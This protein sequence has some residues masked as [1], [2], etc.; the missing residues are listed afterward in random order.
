[1]G[2]RVRGANA[3][4][5]APNEHSLLPP[6]NYEYR[7]IGEAK[8][9]RTPL[10]ILSCLE[11]AQRPAFTLGR[12]CD[13]SH[14]PSPESNTSN[15]STMVKTTDGRCA[16]SGETSRLQSCHLVPE[17]EAKWWLDRGMFG[18]TLNR[19]GI[20]SPQNSL[21][22]RDDLNAQG[23]GLGHFVFAPYA[24][25]K[26]LFHASQTF[27][28]S[29]KKRRGI[30][31]VVEQTTGLAFNR[32]NADALKALVVP[33]TDL[34]SRRAELTEMM[35][36]P[37][38]P[39]MFLLGQNVISK[40]LRA[41]ML[42]FMSDVPAMGVYPGFSKVMRL[43]HKYRQEHPE[44]SAVWSARVAYVGEYDDEQRF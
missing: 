21:A 13:E 16:V 19:Q 24:G 42:T 44:V 30:L 4:L 10:H 27:F 38:P 11:A 39:S 43:E 17:A 32:P 31:T 18:L 35:L 37:S 41:W 1:M 9:K 34:T 3:G 12:S 40:L 7:V 20:N 26:G 25:M 14:S 2:F 5:T 36:R 28:V 22:M 8:E 33:T 29:S 6:G 15:Y 23:M